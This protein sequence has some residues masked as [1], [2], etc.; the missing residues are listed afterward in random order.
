[1]RFDTVGVQV[2]VDST[3]SVY[4]VA[5]VANPAAT[6]TEVSFSVP[7]DDFV[8]IAIYDRLGRLIATPLPHEWLTTGRYAIDVGTSSLPG[9]Y[10]VGLRT[11]HAATVTKLVVAH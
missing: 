1:V 11:D 6:S 10:F 9:T 5:D 2:I 4:P 3:E 8:E 7:I